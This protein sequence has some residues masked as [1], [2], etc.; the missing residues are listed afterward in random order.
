MEK[1]CLGWC[2][3][4]QTDKFHSEYPGFYGCR[5]CGMVPGPGC[6]R[7]KA[8]NREAWVSDHSLE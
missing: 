4:H 6:S 2:Y 5:Q 1:H 8:Y 7:F 3:M